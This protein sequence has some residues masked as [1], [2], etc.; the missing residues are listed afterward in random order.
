MACI[1][2]HITVSLIVGSVRDY[3]VCGSHSLL[4]IELKFGQRF[5]DEPFHKLHHSIFTNLPASVKN[6]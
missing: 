3:W 6:L 4:N 1:G 2:I 5:S